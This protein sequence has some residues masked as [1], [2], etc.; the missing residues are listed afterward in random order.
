MAMPCVGH[1]L[2]RPFEDSDVDPLYEIQGD[3]DYMRFTYWAESRA[4]CEDRLRHYAETRMANGFAPWTIVHRTDARVIG[5]GGLNV[6][7][8]APGWGIEVTYFIHREYE[9][10]GYATEVVRAAVREGFEVHGLATIGA[11]AKPANLGSIRVLE[12]CG[13]SLLR[14]EPA[15]ER[16]HYEAH[17]EGWADGR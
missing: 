4:A 16:D 5:W 2:L 11:F 17:R 14:Y 15:L 7:P 12:K 13:F 8:H 3:R 9:G 10:R 6:D 1:L